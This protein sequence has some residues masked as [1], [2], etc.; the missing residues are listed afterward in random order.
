MLEMGAFD[1]EKKKKNTRSFQ[2]LMLDICKLQTKR[3]DIILTLSDAE[4]AF[5]S[6][7][8]DNHGLNLQPNRW[9]EYRWAQWT[10][11]FEAMDCEGFESS[12][13][14]ASCTNTYDHS[15]LGGPLETK[16]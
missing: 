5:A 1:H 14:D 15:S 6:T 13:S 10:L 12:R 16:R 11:A 4:K 8:A 9:D 3:K 2:D 7:F